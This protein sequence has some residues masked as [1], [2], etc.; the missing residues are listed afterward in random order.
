MPAG[1]S[2]LCGRED[3]C[4]RKEALHLTPRVLPDPRARQRRAVGGILLCSFHRQQDHSPRTSTQIPRCSRWVHLISQ[5]F[6]F[7]TGHAAH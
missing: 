3:A 6:P 7:Q 4:L 2:T 1:E 5:A